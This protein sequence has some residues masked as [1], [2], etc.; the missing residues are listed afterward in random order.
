VAAV[1]ALERVARARVA[2]GLVL[3]PVGPA[4]ELGVVA[5]EL[6]VLVLVRVGA[7]LV[8]EAAVVA[9]VLRAVV[10][11]RRVDGAGSPVGVR[12]ARAV[13]RTGIGMRVLPRTGEGLLVLGAMTSLRGTRSVGRCPARVGGTIAL[14]GTGATIGAVRVAGPVRDAA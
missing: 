13:R 9:E 2:V 12:V 10:V 14:V 11:G 8:L 5:L 7:G 4:P 1:R 6:G 3:D